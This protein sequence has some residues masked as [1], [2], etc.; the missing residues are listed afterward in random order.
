MTVRS[1]FADKRSTS[2]SDGILD[3]V[4]FALFEGNCPCAVIED[5]DPA[6]PVEIGKVRDWPPNLF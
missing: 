5:R 3:A 4:H 6:Y 1:G 2:S